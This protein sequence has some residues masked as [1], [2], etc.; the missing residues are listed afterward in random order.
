MNMPLLRIARMRPATLH[1][2]AGLGAGRH[3]GIAPVELGGLVLAREADRIGVDPHPAQASRA[4]RAAPG[5]DGLS[6]PVR[7]A[8]AGELS[9][10]SSHAT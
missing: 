2:V 1:A 10:A 5:E 7:A 8:E 6:P 9:S 3:L 4:C